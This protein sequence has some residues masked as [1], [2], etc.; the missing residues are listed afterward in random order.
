MFSSSARHDTCYS[1]VP[2]VKDMVPLEFEKLGCLGYCA[3]DDTIS[4]WIK[5]FWDEVCY[6]VR[7]M[8]YNLRW[9]ENGATPCRN[10]TDKWLECKNYGVV[11]WSVMS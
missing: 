5:V 4:R 1:P 11:P 3:I 2:S 6:E 9:F 8:G 10:S 7:E